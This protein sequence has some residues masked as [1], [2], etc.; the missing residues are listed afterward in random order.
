MRALRL[1]PALVI[2]LLSACSNAPTVNPPLVEAVA[3]APQRDLLAE[4]RAA[5]GDPIDVIEVAPL[6]D[7]IVADLLERADQ[8]E[9]AGDLAG[10]EQALRQAV[11][12]VPGDPDLMQ[13]RA[14]FLLAQRALDEA[15]QLA[16]L[17]FERGPRLGSLCRRN[18]TT[19]R[20]ARE[21]RGDAGG[22]RTA[23]R[24]VAR[25]LTEPPVRM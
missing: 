8:A 21:E 19:V 13:R 17:S 20:L 15:E 14:E 1:L 5:A 9:R 7:A 12:L 11:E 6:R 4:V 22:A 24:Q 2:A 3:P 16:A 18:W 25:C 10:A 23:A